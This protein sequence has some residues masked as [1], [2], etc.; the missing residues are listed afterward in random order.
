MS[1]IPTSGKAL[2]IYKKSAYDLMRASTDPADQ[3]ALVDSW[4]TLDMLKKV[5]AH[6]RQAAALKKTQFIL[7]K[8]GFTVRSVYRA[9]TTLEDIAWADI[10]VPCGGDGTVLEASHY[11]GKTPVLAVNLD[12]KT[13]YGAWCATDADG[14]ESLFANPAN[15]FMYAAPRM[16]ASINGRDVRERGLNNILVRHPT[17]GTM[18]YVMTVDGVVFTDNKDSGVMISTAKGGPGWMTKVGGIPMHIYDRRLQI[19]NRETDHDVGGFGEHIQIVSS[20]R[21]ACVVIDTEY[22]VHELGYNEVLTIKQGQPLNI[23]LPKKN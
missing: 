22:V 23:Y 15:Y 20:L 16:Q 2:I 11:I 13:S 4:N 8:Q 3:K 1:D 19:K 5:G 18:R 6:D 7:Q 14:L 9:D 10:V 21:K 17:D 12:P